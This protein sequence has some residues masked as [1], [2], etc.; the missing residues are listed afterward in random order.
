M[1]NNDNMRCSL[2]RAHQIILSNLIKISGE[3][4]LLN[5]AQQRI[6]FSDVVA[7]TP[8]PS[9]DESTRDGYVIAPSV[10]S[11]E[12]VD[13]YKIIDEIP[14]GKPYLKTLLAG[15]A[16]K[17]M[18]GGCIPKGGLRVVP[19]EDCIEQNGAVIFSERSLQRQETFI[20]KE[21]S[22]IADGE[23]LVPSG[24]AL[25]GGHL[26]LIATCGIH[27]IEV[28]ARPLVGFACTGSELAA[29]SIGLGIGQKVSS[30]S[31]L[32]EGQ[33]ASVGAR[34]VNMGIIKDTEQELLDLFAKVTTDDLDVLI[35]TGGM[36]P[37]KYDLVERVFAEAGG[38]VLFNS[39]AMRPGKAVLFGVLG[40]TLFF[41]LPGPP[42]AVRTLLNELVGPA[43]LAMQGVVG[44]WPK[45]VQAHLLHQVSIKRN[46]VLRLKDG[47]LTFSEGKCLVRFAE[48]LEIPN[49]F[50]LL[51][52][53]QSHYDEG[54]LVEVHLV[55]RL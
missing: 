30:N 48:R 10:G 53:G 1:K 23:L 7:V 25:Q 26:A 52:P 47:V 55:N 18:T 46:D 22:E 37:G 21:G 8:Q 45:E 42:Y 50:V 44:S 6:T 24:S 39:I 32:I 12:E 15:T 28:A 33:I 40:R 35:T 19:S 20:R 31:F 34:S 2:Q 9:F 14:A 38:K 17:I 49:C 54:A 13:H 43:L 51:P 41:G 36:G 27:S 29:T 5:E 16:C 11:D 4:I 3:A